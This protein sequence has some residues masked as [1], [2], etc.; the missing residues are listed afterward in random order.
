MK[1]TD[2]EAFK[3]QQKKQL[4]EWE[5]TCLNC[6]ACC[7]ALDGDP[8]ENLAFVNGKSFCKVYDDRFREH[9]TLKGRSFQCVSIRKILQKA[10]VGNRNC[11]YKKK[12]KL[13]YIK[14]LVN[15]CS[16]NRG[17]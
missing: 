16:C 9:S 12:M 17:I 15:E 8:C 14:E 5:S 4:D 11:A 6:G 10:W 13:D 3:L 2:D 7:G 1:K